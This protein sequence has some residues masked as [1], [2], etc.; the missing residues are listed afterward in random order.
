MAKKAGKRTDLCR[1]T[2]AELALAGYAPVDR[3]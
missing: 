1:F 3:A 2:A